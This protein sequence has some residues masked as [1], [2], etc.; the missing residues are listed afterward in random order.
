VSLSPREYVR[1]ILDEIDFILS[2]L[3]GQDYASFS[4]NPTLACLCFWS[5]PR[6]NVP[7]LADVRLRR[8]GGQPSLRWSG[9]AWRLCRRLI[10]SRGF[11]F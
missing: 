4:Q 5:R 2:Q 11:A 10:A 9:L 6:T 3:P 7:H 8:F 1:H